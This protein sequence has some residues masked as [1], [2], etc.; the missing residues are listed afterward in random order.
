MA[1]ACLVAIIAIA[2][3]L[4]SF[5]FSLSSLAQQERY[6]RNLITEHPVTSWVLGFFVYLM[7]AL[8]PGT[9]GKAIAWGWLFGFWPA[10][11][12]VNGA[13]T[14]AALICF[15]LSRYLI[16]DAVESRYALQLNGV[17]RA[18]E[19]NGAFYVVLLR[20][21]PVSFSLTN[22][23][24]GATS[25][26]RKTYW[27]ATQLGLLPG[28]IVFVAVGAHLPSL[29]EVVERGISTVFSWQLVTALSLL[30]LFTLVVP[31]L[32]RRMIRDRRDERD[33]SD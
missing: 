31:L 3:W 17:N 21:V 32:L 14:V 5:H 25:L 20:V 11:V 26:D 8:V 28:N 1:P 4:F 30:S 19:R 18:L 9:R 33:L 16:R 13:L 7:I 2:V 12:I 15:C 23:L 24:L 22:Y 6:F 10:L 27:W 29:S